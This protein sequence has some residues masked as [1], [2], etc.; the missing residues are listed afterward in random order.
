MRRDRAHTISGPSPQRIRSSA[1][2][3]AASFSS[4][5]PRHSAAAGASALP[6]SSRSSNRGS[7]DFPRAG[8]S[9]SQQHPGLERAERVTG[10]S[11]QFVF[12]QLYHNSWFGKMTKES[13]K[14]I[15]L[16]AS[17]TIEASIRNLDR[18]HA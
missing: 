15:L 1:S 3:A 12:L 11:P 18:I 10:V 9:A 14:P 5:S 17:S 16:P 13:E 7:T 4:G 8:S 2:A 6:Q